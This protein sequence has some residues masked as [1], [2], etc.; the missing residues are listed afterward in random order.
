METGKAKRK[1]IREQRAEQFRAEKEEIKEYLKER[2]ARL[3]SGEKYLL[4]SFPHLKPGS[5]T[6]EQAVEHYRDIMN[7]DRPDKKKK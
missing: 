2:S 3:T 6:M 5:H 7:K 1:E 4:R